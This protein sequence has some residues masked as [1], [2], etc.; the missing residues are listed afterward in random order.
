MIKRREFFQGGILATLLP[1]QLKIQ[2][3]ENN[4]QKRI[5]EIISEYASQGIHR[6][7]SEVDHISADWLKDRIASLG[8]EPRE[9]SFPFQRVQPNKATLSF[10][11]LTLSGEPLY[12]CRYTDGEGVSGTLGEVGSNADIGVAMA[13]PGLELAAF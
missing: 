9:S 8:V 2:A 1:Y 5:A 13:L 6:T 4:M 11:E 7:G 3:A 12:D 10:S